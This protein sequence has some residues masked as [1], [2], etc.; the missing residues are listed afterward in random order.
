[1]ARRSAATWPATFGLPDGTVVHAI[2]GQVVADKLLSESRWA[3]ETRKAALTFATSLATG[4]VDA[5]KM[6]EWLRK[7]HTDRYR[8]ETG[9]VS[10]PGRQALPTILP[11]HRSQQGQAHGLSRSTAFWPRSTRSIPSCGSKFWG[12][13]FR[14]C[15]SCNSDMASFRAPLFDSR[16]H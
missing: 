15:R 2:P 8:G 1:M 7:S 3:Y 10:V 11:R 16:Q 5:K 14:S 4:D 12:R 13:S 6:G 9:N